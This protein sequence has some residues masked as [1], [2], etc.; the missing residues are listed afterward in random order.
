MLRIRTAADADA[1]GSINPDSSREGSCCCARCAS[2]L[3]NLCLLLPPPQPL[4]CHHANTTSLRRMYFTPRSTA[5]A[6]CSR[7]SSPCACSSASP[8]AG[9]TL[10]SCSPWSP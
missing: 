6:S 10:T 4:H 1:L 5:A 8:A 3:T 2:P 9:A 7:Q